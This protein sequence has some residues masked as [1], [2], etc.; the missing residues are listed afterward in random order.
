M[1]GPHWNAEKKIV[2]L[3]R[4]ILREAMPRTC[5]DVLPG[6]SLLA[7]KGTVVGAHYDVQESL[8]RPSTPADLQAIVEYV[9]YGVLQSE[10][11]WSEHDLREAYPQLEG[12]TSEQLQAAIREGLA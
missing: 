9:A 4:D 5:H 10:L 6:E 2:E 3:H 7:P 8:E 1:H 11:D 12:I